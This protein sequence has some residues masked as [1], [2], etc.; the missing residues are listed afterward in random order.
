MAILAEQ[1]QVVPIECDARIIQVLRCQPDLVMDLERT[2]PGT[3]VDDPSGQTSFT[4][5]TL[6]FTELCPAL[7]PWRRAVEPIGELFV[8]N[9]H[10]C[11]LSIHKGRTCGS[12]SSVFGPSSRLGGV[13]SHT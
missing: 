3:C 6:G 4:E 10:S 5:S 1:L 9:Y 8:H 13:C 2:L 7:L 12:A 11:H